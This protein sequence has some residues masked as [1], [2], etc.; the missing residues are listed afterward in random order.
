MR[1]FEK[2]KKV[3]DAKEKSRSLLNASLLWH[4]EQ[5]S[6]VADLQE[7]VEY[8]DID[9]KQMQNR[10]RINLN[11]AILSYFWI[12]AIMMKSEQLK[13]DQIIELKKF[14]EENTLLSTRLNMELRRLEAAEGFIGKS[15][16]TIDWAL[17]RTSF[18][19]NLQFEQFKKVLF[20]KQNR[21]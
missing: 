17:E 8:Q 4:F 13:I 14:Q 7:K 18:N 11:N 20:T 19:M 12:K 16:L 9:N 15:G 5:I 3:A 10:L 2:I 1:Q 21:L 6:Q